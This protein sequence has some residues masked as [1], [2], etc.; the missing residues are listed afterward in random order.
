VAR[1]PLG[2]VGTLTRAG[3]GYASRKRKQELESSDEER[4][5]I[6]FEKENLGSLIQPDRVHRS[7]Y[8]DPN[9]FELE[10]QRIF[11]KS[12]IYVGHESLVPKPGDYMA[13]R[14]GTQPVV[15]SRHSDGKIYVRTRAMGNGC[16][17]IAKIEMPEVAS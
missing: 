1:R 12:W 5:V 17:S 3:K 16:A 15:L 9:I 2:G 4:K 7:I 11:G 8:V 14:M 10:M 6:P 13:T